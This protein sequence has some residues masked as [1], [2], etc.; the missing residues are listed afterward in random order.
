MEIPSG[1]QSG[2]DSPGRGSWQ[3]GGGSPQAQPA[4]ETLTGS[5]HRPWGPGWGLAS[6]RVQDPGE[7]VWGLGT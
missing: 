1:W 6:V 3:Q 7:P 2:P 4:R 5:P